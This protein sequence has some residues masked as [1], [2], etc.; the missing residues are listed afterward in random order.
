MLREF[1]YPLV[2]GYDSIALEADVELGGHDQIFNLLVGRDLMKEEGL[3]SQVVLT[4]PLLVGTDGVEKMSKSLGNAIDLEDPPRE[5]YGKTMSIPDG[6]MW[7]WYLLL[8]DLA[9]DFSALN[10]LPWGNQDGF[11]RAGSPLVVPALS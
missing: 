2:Q 8:T 4:V 1:L 3:E 6:L 11:H 7:E 9:E 10:V 5:F